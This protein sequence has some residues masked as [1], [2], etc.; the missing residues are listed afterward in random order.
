MVSS[1]PMGAGMGGMG[2]VG[3]VPPVGYGNGVMLQGGGG[4][5]NPAGIGNGNN[6]GQG[7]GSSVTSANVSDLGVSMTNPIN[8][9]SN[10]MVSS[11]APSIG[12]LGGN[13]MSNPSYQSGSQ[14]GMSARTQ[15][16]DQSG[17]IQGGGV[18]SSGDNNTN[19][20]SLLLKGDKPSVR[21]QMGMSR[22]LRHPAQPVLNTRQIH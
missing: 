15:A 9:S 8:S 17:Y 18:P 5:A 2:Q 11:L 3:N 20:L 6:N 10:P 12:G 14:V 4:M 16:G 13:M 21:S 7:N 1:N 19:V 22:P